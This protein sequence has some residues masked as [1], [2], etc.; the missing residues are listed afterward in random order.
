MRTHKLNKLFFVMSFMAVIALTLP[1]VA[2][3]GEG[4]GGGGG[5][6]NRGGG[7]AGGR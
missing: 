4:R 2:Q 5:Q 3:R 7:D 1:C 6:G